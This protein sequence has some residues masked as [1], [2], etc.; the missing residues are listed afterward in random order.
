MRHRPTVTV[1]LLVALILPLPARTQQKQVAQGLQAKAPG[2]ALFV[3]Y[4]TSRHQEH[5]TAEVFEN[6]ADQMALFLK[7][8]NV[9]L[10]NGARGKTTVTESAPSIPSLV[11]QV[12]GAG[13]GSLI[14]LTVDRPLKAW[15]KLQVQCYDTSG[16][17]LWEEST[18]VSGWGHRG[19]SAEVRDAVEEMEKVLTPRLGQAGMPVM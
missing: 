6:I 8:H 15:V 18:A 7:S 4:R 10:L 11:G 3:A 17:L 19:S 1:F 12:R 9:A 5:S 13:G 16:Q 2:P 14:L